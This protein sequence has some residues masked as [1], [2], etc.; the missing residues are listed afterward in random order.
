MIALTMQP[1]GAAEK[2]AGQ[3]G[4][5]QVPTAGGLPVVIQPQDSSN[6]IAAPAASTYARVA[7]SLAAIGGGRFVILWLVI[8]TTPSNLLVPATCNLAVGAVVPMP[9]LPSSLTKNLLAPSEAVTF[10]VPAVVVP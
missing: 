6:E 2:P 9:T 8:S 10:R 3:A 5:E 4:G 7:A 1:T